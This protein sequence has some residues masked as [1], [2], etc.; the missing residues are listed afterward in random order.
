MLS[1]SPEET[2][3]SG[4]AVPSA[5]A[6]PPPWLWWQDTTILPVA[7]PPVAPRLAVVIPCH[8]VDAYLDAAL[9][10]LAAQPAFR[11]AQVI[12]VDDGSTDA[13][14]RLLAEFAEQHA[15]V[16]LLRLP[17]LGPGAARNAG[18]ER[19]DAPYVTFLDSDDVLAE[20]AL[21]AL[22]DSARTTG[23]DL[24]IGDHTAFPERPY[25]PWKRHF[26]SGD[27]LITHPA[28]LEDLVFSCAAWGRL[29]RTRLL[30]EARLR[31][32]EGVLFEDAWLTIPALLAA[33]R[34]ALLDRTV[35]YYRGR[36]DRGSIMDA[37]WRRD[38]DYWDH[39]RL[40]HR[41]LDLARLHDRARQRLVQRFATRT[42]QGFLTRAHGK[43]RG[44]E[45]AR[46]F[47]AVREM[48]AMLPE[49][50]TAEYVSRA[51]QRL[52]L[53]AVR[54]GDLALFAS[55][56]LATAR[57]PAL[58]LDADGLFLTEADDDGTCRRLRVGPPVAGPFSWRK[59]P[60]A[61]TGS[62]AAAPRAEGPAAP[63]VGE[64]PGAPEGGAPDGAGDAGSP[65]PEVGA[66][67]AGA[68]GPGGWLSIPG[69]ESVLTE[70]VENRIELVFATRR[71]ETVIPAEVEVSSPGVLTW[72][73]DSPARALWRR[74]TRLALRLHDH[75][76]SLDIPLPRGRDG[77]PPR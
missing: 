41:L 68:A 62:P 45:L 31:F 21:D 43:L 59:G 30:E 51:D 26:G 73:A 11:D 71:G 55:P 32:A 38:S 46:L 66:G 50:V 44:A 29:F 34:T 28:D 47:A 52:A 57:R 19:V 4:S 16:T 10:S 67:L 27:Q 36:E 61:V 53:H 65:T 6:P 8:N 2:G 25:G 3:T 13:T 77:R 63:E 15:N 69:A 56:D 12:C 74:R 72:R 7:L 48:Y 14:P 24:V 70:S 54:T 58:H 39:L 1:P 5:S 22:L 23:A 37:L 75:E 17:G 9:G 33:R 40:N 60:S 64:G 49:E 20:G 18:L 35:V 42:Y 76:R